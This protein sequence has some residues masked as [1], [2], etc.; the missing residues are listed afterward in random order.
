MANDDEEPLAN[1]PAPWSD[2]FRDKNAKKTR[3]KLVSTSSRRHG[4]ARNIDDADKPTGR[5]GCSRPVKTTN[6]SIG[7]DTNKTTSRGCFGQANQKTASMNNTSKTTKR[8]C[9]GAGP[10]TSYGTRG[11][12]RHGSGGGDCCRDC[13]ILSCANFELRRLLNRGRR[14]GREGKDARRR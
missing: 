8:V 11:S 14:E 2:A 3:K 4:S 5:G 13:E 12:G 1:K 6:N 10:A 9:S 7:A